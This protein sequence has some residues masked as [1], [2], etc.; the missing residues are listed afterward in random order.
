MDVAAIDKNHPSPKWIASLR[1]RFPCEKEM[2]RIFTRKL[3]RRNGPS[4]SPVSLETLCAS[5]HS[6]LAN[7]L[8]DTFEVRD[9]KWL[10]GGASKLQVAFKLDW[11]QPGV[12]RTIT[13]MVIRMEP[14]ESI[15]E[16]SR[17]REFQVIRAVGE[18]L[19]VPPVYWIDQDGTHFPYPAIIYGFAEGVAKPSGVVSNVTGLGT[20]FGPEVR[21][22][23]AKQYVEHLAKLHTWD[24]RKADLSSLDVPALGTDAISMHLNWWERIWEEDSN[25]DIPLMRLAA[26]WLRDNMP[27][28]DRLSLVHGDFRAGNFLYTEH[29]DRITAWLDWELA[30]LGDFHYDVAFTTLPYFSHYSEDGSTLLA[31]GMMPVQALYEA[32]EKASGLTI[33][34]KTID[35]YHIF[36][37]YR[38]AVI[39]IASGYRPARNGKTHQ[40]LLLTWVMG[41]GYPVLAYLR[42]K[43]EEV[44]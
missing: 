39:V 44:G 42:D 11:N 7:E 10:S 20:N 14:A 28:V 18:I 34:Q 35:Y 3:Q 40:D 25:R 38:T 13:P 41:L 29:D 17:L 37:S 33:D 2:D 22:V 26:I 16:T 5:L 21:K 31:S 4:Y 8:K 24:W 36:Q 15:V 9:A 32:F 1:K 6:L 30:Y 19:P 43:L 27:T 23:L 12:G